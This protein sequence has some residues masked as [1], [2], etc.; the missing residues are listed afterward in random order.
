MVPICVISDEEL[1]G[2][3]A[4]NQLLWQPCRT[5]N[6]EKVR[7]QTTAPTLPTATAIATD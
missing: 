2:L 1:K 7:H 6:F 5:K 3:H 4:L